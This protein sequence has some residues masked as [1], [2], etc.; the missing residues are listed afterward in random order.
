MIIVRLRGGFGNQ[1]FQYAAGLSLANHLKTTLKL[2]AYAYQKHEYRKF[3]LDNFQIPVEIASQ[4]EIN[5]F[6][7]FINVFK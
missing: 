4:K 6:I 1:L 5:K 3:E 7:S 2:D